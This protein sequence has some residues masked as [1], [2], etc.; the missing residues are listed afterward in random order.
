MCLFASRH[1]CKICVV[2][3]NGLKLRALEYACLWI[4]SICMDTWAY[5]FENE[6]CEWRKYCWFNLNT[7][8]H[9]TYLQSKSLFASPS[10]NRKYESNL[11]WATW[12]R[13]EKVISCFISLTGAPQTAKSLPKKDLH[14]LLQIYLLGLSIVV[15]ADLFLNGFWLF[16]SL[17]LDLWSSWWYF[18]V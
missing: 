15:Y 12:S 8:I 3:I 5:A 13:Q 9:L 17:L 11:K 18:L 14:I 16:V 2:W 4:W 1:E 10:R 6:S 7:Y